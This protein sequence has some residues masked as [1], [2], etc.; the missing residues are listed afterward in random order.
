MPTDLDI[1]RSAAVLI[2]HHG[3]NAKIEACLRADAMM[4]KGNLDANAFWLDVVR[5]IEDLQK[6]NPGGRGH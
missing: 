4:E 5:A 1:Y 3:E 6:G 2:E